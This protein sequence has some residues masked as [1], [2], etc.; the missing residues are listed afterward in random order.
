MAVAMPRV[1]VVADNSLIVEAVRIGLRNS[2]SSLH[3]LGHVVGRDPSVN[4][5]LD[6]APDVVLLDDMDQSDQAVTMVQE[7]KKADDEVLV[8][9]LTVRLEGSWLSR[10]FA[11]GAGGAFSKSMQL[12]ALATLI[13]ATLKGQI[14]HAPY[15][16]L[17]PASEHA[18]M[19]GDPATL[20]P[21]E[22]EILR[23]VVAGGSNAEIAREL[24]ITQPTV[25]FHLRNVY[26]KLGVGNRTE[27]CHYA[28]MRGLLADAVRLQSGVVELA[29]T[30]T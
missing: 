3:V 29:P 4:P 18:L 20:T 6:A 21:R 25:K 28:H 1:V 19:A 2:G 5:I 17:E 11:A 26:R 30:G 16:L 14:V 9:V 10:A 12:C 27:A 22:L 7:I 8:M 24:W 13:R 23:I 15:K